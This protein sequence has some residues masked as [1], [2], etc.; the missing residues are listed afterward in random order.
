LT[1]FLLDYFLAVPVV[2]Q[3]ARHAACID[4]HSMLLC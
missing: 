1:H 4:Q 2:I 3:S